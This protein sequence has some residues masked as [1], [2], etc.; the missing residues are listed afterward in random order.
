MQLRDAHPV[1][2]YGVVR[3]TLQIVGPDVG[4]LEFF[5]NSL[6]STT[7]MYLRHVAMRPAFS[8]GPT[9][10]VRRAFEGRAIEGIRPERDHPRHCNPDRS[11]DPVREIDNARKPLNPATFTTPLPVVQWTGIAKMQS[12]HRL[13]H[14]RA[15]K[16]ASA[17]RY[18]QV[19]SRS[20]RHTLDI[21]W[22]TSNRSAP[23]PGTY[24]SEAS[25]EEA[26]NAA[27]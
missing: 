19:M 2:Q 6:R 4:A 5:S 14:T 11:K 18:R 16:S 12:A 23:P 22:Y 25:L 10:T 26:W 17:L 1:S 13:G 20:E 8:G 21:A 15:R 27:A 24:R 9:T 7:V 3:V